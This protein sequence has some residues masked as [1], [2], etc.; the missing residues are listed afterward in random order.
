MQGGGSSL[1][2]QRLHITE[3]EFGSTLPYQVNLIN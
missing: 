1:A 3:G 2:A